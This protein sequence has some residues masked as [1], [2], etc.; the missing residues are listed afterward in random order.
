MS[1]QRTTVL[2][3]A[4]LLMAGLLALPPLLLMTQT[5]LRLL[6]AAAERALPP[7][8]LRAGAVAGSLRDG[9]TLSDLRYVTDGLRVTA[10]RV[11]FSL[12][13]STLFAGHLRLTRLEVSGLE[14][15]LA[16]TAGPPPTQLP[17]LPAMPFDVTIDDARI[18][19]LRVIGG[20]AAPLD[21]T[22]L[23][24]RL[25]WPAG[26]PLTLQG[27]D[28]ALA[29]TRVHLEGR[30]GGT[31]PSALAATLRWE[32]GADAARVAGAGEVD[33]AG[34]RLAFTH[35]L[36][37][38]L[39][40]QAQGTLDIADGSPRWQVALALP[41]GQPL[42]PVAAID[43]TL[44][45]EASASGV[46][47]A[48][49]LET[50][51]ALHTREFGHW[52]L[53]ARG[54]GD[55][56]G[57]IAIERF[58]LRDA[59]AAQLDLQG[60]LELPAAGADVRVDLSGHWSALR[61]PLLA[62]PRLHSPHGRF[63][64]RG[65]QS[66]YA[67]TLRAATRA[68][69]WPDTDWTLEAHGT[70]GELRIAALDATFATG[71]DAHASGHVGWVP[72]LRWDLE[73]QWRE[74]RHTLDD[75][76]QVRSV[77]GRADAAGSLESHTGSSEFALQ[78][79]DLPAGTVRGSFS[80]T[81]DSLVV[82]PFVADTGAG[83]LSGDARLDW[84]GPA[85]AWD[86]RLHGSEVDP[87]W[88]AADFPGSLAFDLQSTGTAAAFSLR[89][90]KLGGRLRGRP[91]G[92]EADIERAGSTLT[93]H[94]LALRSG[95][96]TLEATGTIGDSGSLRW[97]VA[98]PAL[99]DLWP[100]AQG[101]LHG[102]GTL[103]GTLPLPATTG[104]LVA[105]DVRLGELAVAALNARWRVDPRATVA[106]QLHIDLQNARRE[107]HTLESL[108]LDAHGVL[109]D[110]HLDLDARAGTSRLTLALDGDG[111]TPGRWQGRLLSGRLAR[112]AHPDLALRAPA[113]FAIVGPVTD[114]TFELARQCWDGDGALC[115]A[116]AQDA[117]GRWQLAI[118]AEAFELA[119][120]PPAAAWQRG[121]VTGELALSG[122]ALLLDSATGRLA[123]AGGALPPLGEPW[124]PIVHRGLEWRVNTTNGE[125]RLAANATIVE[126]STVPLALE[127]T[128]HDGPWPL[129][130]WRTLPVSGRLTASADALA[131]WVTQTDDIGELRGRA[132]LDLALTGTVADPQTAGRATLTVERAELNRLG[133]AIEEAALAITASGTERFDVTGS[134]R[135]GA[136]RAA[137]RGEAGQDTAGLFATLAVTSERLQVV[138]LPEASLLASVDLALD[139]RAALTRLRG[140]VEI[141]EGHFAL[142]P[143]SPGTQRSDDVI[144]VGRAPPDTEGSMLD[145]DIRVTLGDQVTLAAQG[146]TG[147]L[148]GTLR[149]SDRPRQATRA[150]GELQIADGLYSAYGQALTIRDSRVFY[151]G[152]ALDDPAVDARAERKVDDITAG[153]RV[154]GRL[155][156]PRTTL[157]STPALPDGDILSYLLIGRPLSG[158]S[159]TDAGALIEAASALGLRRGNVLTERIARSFGL[160]ELKLS[161][162]PAASDLALNVGKFLSPKLYV[163]YGVGL[164]DRANTVRLRYLLGKHWSLEAET[165]TRTG[166]DVLY[167]I[168][169]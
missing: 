74:L 120:L 31:T 14:L 136:G 41:P 25:Q 127:L 137:L 85:L 49:T 19:R 18:D 78:I 47:A 112:A 163:G 58:A 90:S 84:S 42:P 79:D 109:A 86:A 71:G 142:R 125:L 28:V 45:G 118:D 16:P 62:E 88:F 20:A 1:R 126:P 108:T 115:V 55:A 77:H 70:P 35:R 80:G 129:E 122:Q 12:R 161:G 61:W 165:G 33:G 116:A 153:M 133:I 67:L 140:T 99:A 121:A 4:S 22:G 98:A 72:G 145:A 32:H 160:D 21:A 128:L 30:W 66:D 107:T 54:S 75:G 23:A 102:H 51:L 164:I 57:V 139:W 95:A 138:D 92:G 101:H 169:R 81:L 158:A 135:S 7:D 156:D 65:R 83:R 113:A 34:S 48:F 134:L 68:G 73:G 89:L 155:R 131:P 166:A 5:G 59:D 110:H 162:S 27:L 17:S 114:G 143:G 69:T 13:P 167:S 82:R 52:T 39:V 94:A 154:S 117:Q 141:P 152:Q 123:L 93:V 9:A 24:A 37:A 53:E 91:L 11:S 147:R 8:G 132:A 103:T 144:V 124:P 87:A 38:P 151:S 119:S 100:A 46:G 146:F 64:L 10:D 40:A 29:D 149:V 96:A 56:Q 15:T 2:V 130:R 105:G 150:S 36:T 3:V 60:V 43:A 168:E 6:L 44:G 26:G 106:Q 97:R 148:Y 157:Y 63:T 50:A 159:S 111:S 76:R 104:E